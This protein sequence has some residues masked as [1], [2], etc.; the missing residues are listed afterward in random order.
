MRRQVM[1][2]FANWPP[3]VE[4]K[5]RLKKEA[6]YSRLVGGSFNKPGK[7]LQ[8]LSWAAARH[9]HLHTCPPNLGGLYRG[10]KGLQSRMPPRWPQQYITVSRLCL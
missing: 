7:S 10:L 5:E 6:D 9:V 8:G 2:W 1:C 3:Y 4:G